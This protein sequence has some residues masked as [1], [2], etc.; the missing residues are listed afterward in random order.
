MAGAAESRATR[1]RSAVSTAPIVHSVSSPTVMYQR[2]EVES[3]RAAR[4]SAD[5]DACGARRTN[6]R[7]R[8]KAAGVPLALFALHMGCQYGCKDG[9]RRGKLECYL[10]VHA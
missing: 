3:A 6:M 2:V 8:R 4:V 9:N 5:G 1:G 10:R 7:A